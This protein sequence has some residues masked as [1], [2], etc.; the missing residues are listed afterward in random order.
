MYKY[1]S[2]YFVYLALVVSRTRCSRDKQKSLTT[3]T[4]KIV[5]DFKTLN[6]NRNVC[7]T[8]EIN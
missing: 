5:L 3:E 4:L 2:E 7:M 1:V 8:Y 6:R